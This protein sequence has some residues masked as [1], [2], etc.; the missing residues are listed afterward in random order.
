[1]D[2][3]T[4]RAKFKALSPELTE[5]GRRRWAAVEAKALGWGG[6][7]LVWRATGIG[8]TTIWRGLKEL[9]AEET[10]ETGRVR[11]PGGGRNSR[12]DEDPG[13][14][15]DLVSLVEPTASGN[16]QSPLCWSSKS[17][18]KLAAGLQSMGH[19][20]SHPTVRDVL[21]KAGYTLQSNLKAQ[22]G[23]SHPDR[24]GQFRYINRRVLAFQRRHQPV[25]SVDTKKKELV[26]NFKNAGREWRPKGTPE[27][28]KVHDFLVP[29]DGKAIPYGVYDLT[30]NRGYVSVGIDH[31]TASFAVRSIKRWW[32][33]MGRPVYRGARSLLITADSGGSN[34]ARVRLWKWELQRLADQTGL[35]ISVL[36][37]P[38]GT[39]KWNKIEH[40]LFSFISANWRGRPL[41]SVVTI[42]HLIAA[43]ATTTGLHVRAEIDMG[44][45]PKGVKVP[46]QEM[47]NLRL[48]R[49]PFHGDWNYTLRPRSGKGAH[50]VSRRQ[51]TSS[52]TGRA[53]NNPS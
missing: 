42:V 4:I 46:E 31:D 23:R 34:G 14:L 49:H 6:I 21:A 48:R 37:F 30:R 39:S 7:R 24:D 18:R 1:V 52:T 9:D 29:E 25:I 43:T 8:K 45:Y 17:L 19:R 28:V 20:I 26:G 22:E 36:H 27:R 5:R 40:R 3:R 15:A 16:P 51:A 12:L 11:K 32:Q 50:C 33:T 44:K 38:P 10:L 35:T 13:L 2:L 41:T 47:A 53:Q